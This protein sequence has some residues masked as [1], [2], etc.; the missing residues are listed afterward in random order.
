MTSFRIVHLS[1]LHLTRSDGRPRSEPDILRPLKGMNEAFRRILRT[2]P[3]QSSH[4][5]LI[6]GDVTDRGDD[7][8]WEVFR[9]GVAAAGVEDRVLLLPGNHDVCCLGAR[10]PGLRRAY[11][12]EDLQ[13]AV[14]GLARGM[15]GSTIACDPGLPVRGFPVVALPDP[16][17]VIFCL[18][19][20]FLGNLNVASNAL[21]KVDYFQLMAL[22]SKMHRYREV[23][24]KI[25]ALHHSPNIP[26]GATARKRGQKP[27]SPL[28]RFGHQVPEGQ[29]RAIRLLC[30]THRVRLLVHG[31]L[32]MAED[33]RVGGVRIVGAP[34]TTEPVA[35]HKGGMDYQFFRFAVHGNGERVS[36]RL[37][38]VT[39]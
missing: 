25:V 26:R 13:R 17:V 12:T 23:P 16:R 27:F 19:S 35:V 9:S 18:N 31:H 24:V 39:V 3:V 14:R 15:G 5:I 29:R 36:T 30:V 2:A 28:A 20:N 6:T 33:R 21:G 10:L 32:H 1:D 22:A 8:S 7:D 4:L 38:T 11:R 37:T 34:A